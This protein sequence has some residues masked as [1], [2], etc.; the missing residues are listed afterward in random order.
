MASFSDITSWQNWSPTLARIYLD[1]SRSS[2][3][4]T[5][6]AG[7]HR[8]IAIESLCWG[9]RK[10]STRNIPLRVKANL[11]QIKR[12]MKNDHQLSVILWKI[13]QVY[14]RNTCYNGVPS[15]MKETA[16][17]IWIIVILTIII[18][19]A[20]FTVA[21]KATLAALVQVRGHIDTRAILEEGLA[22]LLKTAHFTLVF[23]YGLAHWKIK[24]NVKFVLS[25]F[26]LLT[27]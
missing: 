6:G 19:N 26:M 25:T 12:G 20:R 3:S 23:Q 22:R 18:S 4:C 7:S 9:L 1:V 16:S 2:P 17:H 24:I 10:P 15:K 27:F 11:V 21:L 8:P 14:K 5:V 13:H